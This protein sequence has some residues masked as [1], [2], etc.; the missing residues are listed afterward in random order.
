MR[1][2]YRLLLAAR[3]LRSFACGFTAV[4][5][6]ITTGASRHALSSTGP[7]VGHGGACGIVVRT[8][9]GPG[10]PRESEGGE[11]WPGHNFLETYRSLAVQW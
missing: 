10:S 7:D 6:R 11:C 1:R 2:D 4:L 3:V 9:G 8:A 5:L